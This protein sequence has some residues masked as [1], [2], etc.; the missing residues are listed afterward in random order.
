M[1]RDAL[2]RD[3]PDLAI[4]HAR[5]AMALDPRD[6]TPRRLIERARR[7]EPVTREE[8]NR[9]WREAMERLRFA[10]YQVPDSLDYPENWDQISQPPR[11]NRE[12]VTWE[13]SNR[14]WRERR[15]A[16]GESEGFPTPEELNYPE[17]WG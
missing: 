9:R 17:T 11:A 4:A 6:R 12:P 8:F 15:E 5:K 10:S 7:H 2:E 1:S 3:E 16:R 13:E 14:R